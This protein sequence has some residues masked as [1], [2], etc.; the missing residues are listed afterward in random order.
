M[1]RTPTI[2]RGR[3]VEYQALVYFRYYSSVDIIS[4]CGEEGAEIPGLF[5]I[6]CRYGFIRTGYIADQRKGK[7]LDYGSLKT[8][9]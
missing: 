4:A 8:T 6:N 7:N 2:L 5:S 3:G 1:A 9:K